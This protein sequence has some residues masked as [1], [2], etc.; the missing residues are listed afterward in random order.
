LGI[1]NKKDFM[2]YIAQPDGTY[3][4]YDESAAV[5]AALNGLPVGRRPTFLDATD[6]GVVAYLAAQAE[7]A[8]PKE[9]TMRQARLALLQAGLLDS[10]NTAIAGMTGAQK[11]AAEIEWEYSNSLKRSQP[12]VAQL[13]AALG[14]NTTQL[15]ALFLTAATL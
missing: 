6:A 12:L 14:L 5:F 10:V 1:Q 9:V 13:G 8:K 2:K 11:A 7:A 4:G 15:D 3:A